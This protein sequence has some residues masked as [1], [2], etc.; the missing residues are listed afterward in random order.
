VVD[1][2]SPSRRRNRLLGVRRAAGV[3]AAA[4][5]VLAVPLFAVGVVNP[6][7]YVALRYFGNPAFG[8]MVVA[9]LTLAAS[10]LLAPIRNEAAQANRGRVRVAAVIL[11]VVGLLAWPL[12]SRYFG[13]DVTVLARNDSGDRALALVV[14]GDERQMHILAGRGVAVRDVGSLGIACGQIEGLFLSHD[15]VQVTTSYG[16]WQFRLD[17]ANGKPLNILGPRCAGDR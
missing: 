14:S 6:W 17:P 9:A 4:A 11:L 7:R 12:T 5:A 1:V 8:L 10:W 15:E 2:A 13:E 3:L 16:T